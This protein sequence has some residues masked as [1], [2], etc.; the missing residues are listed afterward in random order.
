MHINIKNYSNCKIQ[1]LFNLFTYI[2]NVIELQGYID[3][4]LRFTKPLVNL[5]CRSV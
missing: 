2:I 3:I 1:D 5:I 4:Y